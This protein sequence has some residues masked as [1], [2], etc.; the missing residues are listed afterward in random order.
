MNRFST[1]MLFVV[2][3]C[4]Y[5]Q[6]SFSDVPKIVIPM[7]DLG[8][9]DIVRSEWP[10]GKGRET[11]PSIKFTISSFSDSDSWRNL[12]TFYCREIWPSSSV[13]DTEYARIARDF[14]SARMQY[15]TVWAAFSN[16]RPIEVP[17]DSYGPNGLRRNVCLYDNI[18][19]TR[20]RL[21]FV[22]E[23]DKSSDQRKSVGGRDVL[24]RRAIYVSP[25]NKKHRSLEYTILHPTSDHE[26]GIWLSQ[27]AKSEGKA[28]CK[29]I[30][31]TR[32][33]SDQEINDAI[34]FREGSYQFTNIRYSNVDYTCLADE[35]ERVVENTDYETQIRKSPQFI[36]DIE[37]T[38]RLVTAGGVA[39]DPSS[40]ST[41]K[42]TKACQSSAAERRWVY[43]DT[44]ETGAHIKAG[45]R[46]KLTAVRVREG[47][48]LCDF[49][50]LIVL[51]PSQA[52][53]A[54]GQALGDV[55][56]RAITFSEYGYYVQ[57]SD[58]Y[59]STQSSMRVELSKYE[60]LCGLKVFPI[61]GTPSAKI[62]AEWRPVV[63]K[64]IVHIKGRCYA[65]SFQF[66]EL[67]PSIDTYALPDSIR[68]VAPAT[69]AVPSSKTNSR[70]ESKSTKDRPLK[71]MM[72]EGFISQ[73]SPTSNSKNVLI[74]KPYIQKPVDAKG[75]TMACDDFQY[76]PADGSTAMTTE[77]LEHYAYWF[78]LS[79]QKTAVRLQGVKMGSTGNRRCTF[80][81][82][83][84]IDEKGVVIPRPKTAFDRDAIDKLNIIKW[85]D[86]CLQSSQATSMKHIGM[87]EYCTCKTIKSSEDS[88]KTVGKPLDKIKSSADFSKLF[89]LSSYYCENLDHYKNAVSDIPKMSVVASK[90]KADIATKPFALPEFAHIKV[91]P[92]DPN[93]PI[94]PE[95]KAMWAK[96]FYIHL[97]T[98]GNFGF[99]TDDPGPY[100]YLPV[101]RWKNQNG[102]LTLTLDQVVYSFTL[103][104][105]A[106]AEETT[107]TTVDSTWN[108]FRMTYTTKNK[109]GR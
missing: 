82:A 10:T 108:A 14:A 53:L 92:V 37:G 63:A 106:T 2:L 88:V 95:V 24:V 103:P 39:F 6:L 25:D 43:G 35:V 44:I 85:Y 105:V 23:K 81:E 27:E 86:S 65:D 31:L 28:P 66:T 48:N 51:P 91:V 56:G 54:A 33:V 70:E 40:V 99:N 101:N 79:N 45:M 57:Q 77:R 7:I 50:S 32:D 18:E 97:K 76:M 72:T 16:V 17:S 58:R 4:F 38:V 60:K 102:V 68:N 75:K 52:D 67:D 26:G 47:G 78:D 98:D 9:N 90:S 8:L 59:E 30:V 36:G 83:V 12:G 19:F 34:Y 46:V 69:S 104:T 61:D 29:L 107:L 11:V 22:T 93:S 96:G 74:L 21:G 109:G 55:K 5:P 20:T 41:D 42:F 1:L 100:A 80:T 84:A 49:H 94:A 13:S 64:N 3:S 73:Y 62:I 89:T 87:L 71:P 15:G